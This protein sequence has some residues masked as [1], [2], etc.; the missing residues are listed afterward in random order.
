MRLERLALVAGA[1]ELAL[2]VISDRVWDREG[3]AEPLR[4]RPLAAPYRVGAQ[5]AGMLLPL[6]LH[7][8]GIRM[9]RASSSASIAAV[10]LT[11]IGG[12][13]LRVVVVLAGNASAGKPEVYL[14][15]T[16]MAAND[17]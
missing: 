7:A 15:Q 17:Q 10:L 1:A 16:R 12:Y 9:G 8:W 3:V 4:E 2:S 5:L 14:R 13:C 6:A 11:L